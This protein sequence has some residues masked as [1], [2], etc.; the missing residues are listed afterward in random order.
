MNLPRVGILGMGDMG[1][2]LA[3]SL[4]GHGVTVLTTLEGRSAASCDRAKSSGVTLQARL[5]DVVQTCD[6]FLSVVPPSK[7]DILAEAVASHIARDRTGGPLLFVDC[8]AVTPDHACRLARMIE[9]AGGSFVDG[10]IIGP[11]PGVGTPRLYVCGNRAAELLAFDGMGLIV[12]DLRAPVG[13]ASALKLLFS[14]LNKGFNAL[15]ATMVI[16]A[17]RLDMGEALQAEIE[18]MVPA[19]SKR[20]TAQIPYLPVNAA[21]WVP[22]MHEIAELLSEVGLSPG[23]HKGAAETFGLIANE[24]GNGETRE[25]FDRS[26]TVRDLAR[27]CA[28]RLHR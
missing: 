24:F 8:N 13:R 15:S 5:A 12:R 9:A 26:R 20:M 3:K 2:A 14:G 25:T 27:A 11:P 22:E 23:F 6:V 10:S 4:S 19:L 7:A 18:T 28:A 16:A 17:E 1:A 21:R